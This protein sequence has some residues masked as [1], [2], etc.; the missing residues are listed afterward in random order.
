VTAFSVLAASANTLL[1]V[2]GQ[3]WR[4][5]DVEVAADEGRAGAAV[6]SFPA[7]SLSHFGLPSAIDL[8]GIVFDYQVARKLHACSDPHDPPDERND[9]ARDLVDLLL[10]RDAFYPDGDDL[11]ELRAACLDLFEARTR[12][13]KA[14]GLK[15]RSWPPSAHAHDHWATDY[16]DAADAVGQTTSLTEAAD[17]I[18]EW[19]SRIDSA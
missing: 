11:S 2:S 17:L 19:I 5:I 13:A 4:T 3:T 8:A 18:N 7:P 1:L 15:P 12:D 9:R 16:G 14:L 6:A 10:I